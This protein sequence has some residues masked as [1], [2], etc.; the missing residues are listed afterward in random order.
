[1]STGRGSKGSVTPPVVA[2]IGVVLVLAVGIGIV[3]GYLLALHRSRQV[4]DLAALSAAHEFAEG[5]EACQA[6]ESIAKT[7]NARM[8]DCTV[9][10]DAIEYAITVDV[11]VPI[12]PAIPGLPTQTKARAS[13]GQILAMSSE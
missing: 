3:S 12:N 13:A 9:I 8:T 7:G 4:A 1:M 2:A 6:A 10:G 5:G 11:A